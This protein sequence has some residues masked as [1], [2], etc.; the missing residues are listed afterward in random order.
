LITALPER[1]GEELKEERI[2]PKRERIDPKREL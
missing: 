2:D 1:C